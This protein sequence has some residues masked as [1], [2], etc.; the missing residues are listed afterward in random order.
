[1]CGCVSAKGGRVNPLLSFLTPGACFSSK[2]CLHFLSSFYP[3]ALTAFLLAYKAHG[4]SLKES[5]GSDMAACLW[6]LSRKGPKVR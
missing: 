3:A 6:S 4:G 2:L 5:Q 1:M